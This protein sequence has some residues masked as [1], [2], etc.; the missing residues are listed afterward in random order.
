[1]LYADIIMTSDVSH[2]LTPHWQRFEGLS[3]SGFV[4][5]LSPGFIYFF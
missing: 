1:M 4:V 5:G 2:V 3:N